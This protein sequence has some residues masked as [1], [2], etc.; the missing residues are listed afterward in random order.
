ML[1][2]CGERCAISIPGSTPRKW[3]GTPRSSARL[4]LRGEGNGCAALQAMLDEL[5]DSATRMIDEG[6]PSPKA[7]SGMQWA[8]D[9]ILAVKIEQLGTWSDIRPDIARL[10]P[11]IAKA[12]ALILD[13]RQQPPIQA[14]VE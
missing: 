13:C 3:T 4:L 1:R 12:R 6:R 10:Q 8:E 9:G 5:H 14:G 7:S 2:K 11:E